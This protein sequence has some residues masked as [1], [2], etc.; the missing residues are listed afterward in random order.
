MTI[1]IVNRS[2]EWLHRCSSIDWSGI[3]DEDRNAAADDFTER[4]ANGLESVGFNVQMATGQK[5]TCHGWNGANTFA[6]LTGPV[7]TYDLLTAYEV[8]LVHDTREQAAKAM[9]REWIAK[10]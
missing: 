8:Q 3:A 4:L 6:V 9:R 1:L 10:D 7:G 2:N 5:S